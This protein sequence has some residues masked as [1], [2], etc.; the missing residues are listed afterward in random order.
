MPIAILINSR[1]EFWVHGIVTATLAPLELNNTQG[2]LRILH[3]HSKVVILA[4]SVFTGYYDMCLNTERQEGVV[5]I[6]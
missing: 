2:L 1:R 5:P 6:T 4:G 3:I